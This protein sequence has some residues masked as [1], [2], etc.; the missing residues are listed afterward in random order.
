[1]AAVEPVIAGLVL[2]R[3]EAQR[4]E[5]CLRALAWCRYLIVIDNASKDDTAAIA[6]RFTPHVLHAPVTPD[7]DGLRNLGPAY[8]REHLPD[9][10]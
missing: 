3:D 10:G 2:A 4:I 9:V 6:R 8:A 5:A 7:F 1:M